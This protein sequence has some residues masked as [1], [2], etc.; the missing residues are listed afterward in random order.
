MERRLAAI[1]AAGVLGYGRLMADHA[2]AAQQ[3]RCA[4]IAGDDD[5]WG[6][7]ANS[8]AWQWRAE[9]VDVCDPDDRKIQQ[10]RPMR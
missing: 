5:P 2:R 3:S 7:P 1:F 6:N 10:W 9:A 8:N 4:V